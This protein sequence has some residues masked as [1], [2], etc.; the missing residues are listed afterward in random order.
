MTI[1]RKQHLYF[2]QLIVEFLNIWHFGTVWL[3]SV[4]ISIFAFSDSITIIISFWKNLVLLHHFNFNQLYLNLLILT[5]MKVNKILFYINMVKL[6]GGQY[7]HKTNQIA[8]G[9]ICFLLN[10]NKYWYMH[11]P[12]L[13]SMSIRGLTAVIYSIRMHYY[14]YAC[15]VL[16]FRLTCEQKIIN[17]LFS[18]LLK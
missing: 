3:F 15:V 1:F 2:V 4:I 7:I 13:T 11:I 5:L 14:L 6:T 9:V 8:K 12:L 17:F 10:Y 18:W 16:L